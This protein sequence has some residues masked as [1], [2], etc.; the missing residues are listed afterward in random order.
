MSLDIE[1]ILIPLPVRSNVF[2]LNI[3]K[4]FWNRLTITVTEIAA[5]KIHEM[6]VKENRINSGVIITAIRTHCTGGRGYSYEF[7]FADEPMKEDTVYE[8]KGIKFYIGQDSLRF[9]KGAEVDFKESLA[10]S[11]SALYVNSPNATGKCP[12]GHHDLFE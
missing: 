11:G 10:T 3:T 2:T 1:S 8:D 6:M 9:L 7:A 12:C 4:L 5:S